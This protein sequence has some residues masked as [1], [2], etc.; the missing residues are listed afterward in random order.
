MTAGTRRTALQL[1]CGKG[2]WGRGGVSSEA[3]TTRTTSTHH[4]RRRQL[5]RRPGGPRFGGPG[6]PP[7][8]RRRRMSWHVS[9]AAYKG[10]SEKQKRIFSQRPLFIRRVTTRLRPAAAPRARARAAGLGR[11]RNGQDIG[12]RPRRQSGRVCRDNRCHRR[13][14][15]TTAVRRPRSERC[16]VAGTVPQGRA[17][18]AKPVLRPQ[19]TF[20]HTAPRLRMRTPR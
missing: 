11:A 14:Q 5:R 6:R 18:R 19:C 2:A 1:V 17:R 20:S 12:G 3:R 15:R 8:A 9:S 7:S 10:P 16:V 4:A 13:R